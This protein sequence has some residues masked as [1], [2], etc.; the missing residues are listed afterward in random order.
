[1]CVVN[2]SVNDTNFEAFTSV[3]ECL[4]DVIHARHLVRRCQERLSEILVRS[5]G[6]GELKD[7][8]G[9]HTLDAFQPSQ[10]ITNMTWID[11][12]LNMLYWWRISNERPILTLRKMPDFV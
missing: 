5:F 1:M 12:P 11:M 4:M 3:S 8:N 9:P 2:T 10:I 6:C 7:L